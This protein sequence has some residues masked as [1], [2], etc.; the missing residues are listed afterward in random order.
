MI[1]L[2]RRTILALAFCRMGGGPI[3]KMFTKLFSR[4]TVGVKFPT[5]GRMH[6]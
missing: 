2:L 3:A 6:R 5:A 1:R 4:C